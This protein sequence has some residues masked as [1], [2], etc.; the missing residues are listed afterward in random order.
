MLSFIFESNVF[1]SKF[2]CIRLFILL[3]GIS[4]GDLDIWNTN[5]KEKDLNKGIL[6][7]IVRAITFEC[8]NLKRDTRRM[9]IKTKS[10]ETRMMKS[11]QYDNDHAI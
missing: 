11:R 6:Q 1:I 2:C 10:N 4:H 8:V 7:N 9:M 3:F 5:E